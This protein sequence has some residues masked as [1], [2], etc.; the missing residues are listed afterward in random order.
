M[1][2]VGKY[3][4]YLNVPTSWVVDYAI[5]KFAQIDRLDSWKAK[6]RLA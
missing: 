2:G 1:D 6:F 5:E 4:I 3:M